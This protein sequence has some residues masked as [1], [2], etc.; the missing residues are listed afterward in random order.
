MHTP[1]TL[2]DVNLA[3]ARKQRESVPLTQR[4]TERKNET[5]WMTSLKDPTTTDRHT[6]AIGTVGDLLSDGCSVQCC[7]LQLHS[8]NNQ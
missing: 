3:A 7:A 5:E 2:R 6:L 8:E 1:T 4:R